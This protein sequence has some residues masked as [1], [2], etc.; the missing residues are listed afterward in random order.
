MGH[1]V[2]GELLYRDDADRWEFIRRTARVL[3]QLGAVV[4]AHSE[5][6]NHFH[7]SLL[8]QSAPVSDVMQRIESSYARYYNARH[9]RRGHL[10]RDRFLSKI[11][12][13]ADYRITALLYIHCNPLKA[14]IVRSIE[15]LRAYPFT[16]HAALMGNGLPWIQDA[17][18]LRIFGATRRDAR[19]ALERQMIVALANVPENEERWFTD[20]VSL[21]RNEIAARASS[22]SQQAIAR[23][24]REAARERERVA[25]RQ[26]AWPLA[27]L[28]GDVARRHGV[29]KRDLLRGSRLGEVADVRAILCHLAIRYLA[30]PPS[31]VARALGMT[32]GAVSNAARRGTA[33]IAEDRSAFESSLLLTAPA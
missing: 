22:D 26:L 23:A 2:A 30:Y 16:G 9:G 4:E 27:D 15:Q 3:Q 29:R 25:A 20:E 19:R 6:P 32:P 31:E 7:L 28:I 21:D 13:T 17:S 10:F 8:T 14:G 12:S 18:V 5:M 33:L 11:V 24:T 1:A